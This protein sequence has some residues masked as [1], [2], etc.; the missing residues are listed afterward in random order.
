M[1]ILEILKDVPKA[2]LLIAGLL[3]SIA[4]L[5]GTWGAVKLVKGVADRFGVP[6][7][8]DKFGKKM[9]GKADARRER[10]GDRKAIRAA[11]ATG[12]GRFNP[13]YRRYRKA[14]KLEAETSGLKTERKKAEQSF[15]A[16]QMTNAQGQPTR[17]ANRVAGGTMFNAA[18]AGALQRAL[19]GA[20]F[21]I[22]RAEAEEVEAH[23]ATIDNL[24]AGKL[25]DVI[26]NSKSDTEVAA[27]IERLVQVG[28][29]RDV[30]DVVD[31]YGGNGKNDVINKT[32]ANSLA[33][34]GPG[35]LKKSDIDNIGRG[36]LGQVD[37]A[38]RQISS[39]MGQ[40][41]TKNISAG[42]YSEEKMVAATGDELAYASDQADSTGHLALQKTASLLEVNETL[43]GKI[44]HNGSNIHDL[45]TTGRTVI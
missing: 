29:T 6:I 20:K 21:T 23:H 14:A 32:L 43:K 10:A 19:A 1:T 36:Q 25:K 44:K 41:A 39:S 8:G 35:F 3:V 33:K 27:A 28:T 31:K 13:V 30:A 18:E 37:S 34:D 24:D 40:I 16:G 12:A 7:P 26:A 4:P 15:V 2:T 9:Q 17:F 42:V 45:A 38:G 5:A 11:N 22:E